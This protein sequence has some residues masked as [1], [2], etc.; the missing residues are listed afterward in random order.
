M[1]LQGEAEHTVL[2]ALA[3]NGLRQAEQGGLGAGPRVDT[4]DLLAGF[5]GGPQGSVGSPHDLVRIVQPGGHD[6]LGERARRGRRRGAGRRGR[7]ICLPVR[8]GISACDSGAGQRHAEGQD[9]RS[10]HRPA[11][12]VVH[13]VPSGEVPPAFEAL[14][15]AYV[16]AL[17][18]VI[19]CAVRVKE[20]LWQGR[21]PV[22]TPPRS[23]GDRAA[24]N[25]PGGRRVGTS[26]PADGGTSVRGVPYGGTGRSRRDQA[27]AEPHRRGT[28]ACPPPRGSPEW[29]HFSG[30]PYRPRRRVGRTL[31]PAAPRVSRS[32][33]LSL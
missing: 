8:G 14:R 2:S 16:S 29:L 7:G 20:G 30:V 13:V 12:Y 18:V 21:G 17:R 27:P 23:A 31:F 25:A 24:S 10:R 3:V 33:S 1:L 9:E 15:S 26:S 22:R 32:V 11:Q 5:L 6:P 19:R 4:G 28:V